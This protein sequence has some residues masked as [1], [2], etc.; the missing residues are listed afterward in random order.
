MFR[1]FCNKCSLSESSPG[2]RAAEPRQ[3]RQCNIWIPKCPP[4]DSSTPK[5]LSNIKGCRSS[6]INRTYRKPAANVIIRANIA[7][8]KS[9]ATPRV[10]RQVKGLSSPLNFALSLKHS[11]EK[12]IGGVVGFKSLDLTGSFRSNNKLELNQIVLIPECNRGRNGFKGTTMRVMPIRT[13]AKSSTLTKISGYVN[14]RFGCTIRE[15]AWCRSSRAVYRG[16]SLATGADAAEV[17]GKQ[18]NSLL[19]PLRRSVAGKGRVQR[20]MTFSETVQNS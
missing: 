18:F 6:S 13:R 2:R 7:L 16:R 20:K 1:I 9:G 8:G 14:F 12:D 4:N 17:T 3:Q 10:R 5:A 19:S 15:N 11:P